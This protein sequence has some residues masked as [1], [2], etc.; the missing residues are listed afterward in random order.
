MKIIE[1]DGIYMFDKKEMVF[2]AWFEQKVVRL[3][4]NKNDNKYVHFKFVIKQKALK[5]H[6]N[7]LKAKYGASQNNE[8]FMS[9]YLLWAWKAIERFEIQDDGSWEGILDGTDKPNIGRLINN[10][11]ITT[12]NQLHRWVND[13]ALFTKRTIDGVS[14]HVTIKMQMDSFD[15]I[16]EGDY[17]MAETITGESNVFSS[18]MYDYSISFFQKWYQANKSRILTK[19][20]LEFLDNLRKCVKVEGFT[21]DDVYAVTGTPSADVDKR[22]NRIAKRIEKAWIN[23]KPNFKNRLEI[24]RDEEL[25]MWNELFRLAHGKLEPSIQNQVITKWLADRLDKDIVESICFRVLETSEMKKLNR[26]YKLE[27]NEALEALK[28]K[29]LYAVIAEAED[30]VRALMCASY[31]VEKVVKEPSEKMI[32]WKKEKAMRDK[33]PAQVFVD[34]ELIGEIK[35][36]QK[37]TKN[38]VIYILPSGLEIATDGLLR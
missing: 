24:E 10:I 6:A 13:D 15:A 33:A 20:Q 19:S 4:L 28:G 27:S 7:A 16:L 35:G 26:L 25:E 2:E 37:T 17:G 9:E 18:T 8:D 34:G 14:Q 29:S 22:L 36:G 38:N 30:R 1:E 11:K 23:E 32:E 5:N 12:K 3:R 21:P 31:K